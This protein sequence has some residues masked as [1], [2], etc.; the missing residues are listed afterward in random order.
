LSPALGFKPD[1]KGLNNLPFDP[2]IL[3]NIDQ[4]AVG[5]RVQPV[6]PDYMG[7]AGRQVIAIEAK[8]RSTSIT[9]ATGNY[10][11]AG[12][13]AGLSKLRSDKKAADAALLYVT[14]ATAGGNK[15]TV[16]KQI[17]VAGTTKTGFNIPVVQATTSVFVT[18]DQKCN[19]NQFRVDTFLLAVGNARSGVAVT[20]SDK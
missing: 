5:K 3:Q 9:M 12:Y 15:I 11:A 19:C 1:T 7:N 4:N 2:R 10:Q 16:S 18:D 6:V 13:L 14:N 20:I 17:V 8:L